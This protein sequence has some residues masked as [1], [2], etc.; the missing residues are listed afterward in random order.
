MTQKVA[1]ID[2]VYPVI[3]HGVIHGLNLSVGHVLIFVASVHNY[4][5]SY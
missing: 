5:I 3:W 4:C 2:L 1:Y